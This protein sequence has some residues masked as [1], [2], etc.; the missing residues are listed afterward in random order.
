MEQDKPVG[1]WTRSLS[2]VVLSVMLCGCTG[3]YVGRAR[4]LYQEGRYLESAELLAS[5]E[6]GLIEQPLRR[7]AEYAA[8]RGLANLEL[9]NYPEAMRWMN[10]AYEIERRFPGTLTP[11]DRRDLDPGW[12]TLL[13][14]MGIAPPAPGLA[15]A[16]R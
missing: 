2:V 3:G 15:R 4:M 1:N 11:E 13:A 7:Q 9:G 12:W 14:R 5:R 16:I 10:F 6:H 8:Y